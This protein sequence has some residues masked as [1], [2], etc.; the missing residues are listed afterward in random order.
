MSLEQLVKRDELIMGDAFSLP[1][2]A[3]MLRYECTRE[4]ACFYFIR[5]VE[6][7]ARREDVHLLYSK[8][9]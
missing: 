5:S 6:Y 1:C 2:N 3:F 8:N 9:M 7:Y 4:K